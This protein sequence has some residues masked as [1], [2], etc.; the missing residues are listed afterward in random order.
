ITNNMWNNTIYCSLTGNISID[1]NGDRKA[2]YSLLDM[3][4]LTGYFKVVATYY[5]QNES[6]VFNDEVSWPGGSPPK[7]RPP[8]DFDGSLCPE[9]KGN[10]SVHE[11]IFVIFCCCY[12]RT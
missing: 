2:D 4:P 1:D 3:D 5:G 9:P 12:Y 7:D 8:C 11:N 6:L 10:I